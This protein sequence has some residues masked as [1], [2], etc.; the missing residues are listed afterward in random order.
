MANCLNP[1][2][3]H[4]LR[5]AVPAK[6]NQEEQKKFITHYQPHLK[7]GWIVKVKRTLLPS[8]GK[9]PRL[10]VIGGMCLQGHR[11]LYRQIDRGNR[12]NTIAGFLSFV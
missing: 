1:N 4:W 6:A 2:D 7:Q 3:K 10:H 8:T 12:G 11:I 9:Q 5:H